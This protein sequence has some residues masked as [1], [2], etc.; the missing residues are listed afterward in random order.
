VLGVT[1]CDVHQRVDPRL[2]VERMDD[3]GIDRG[4]VQDIHLEGEV[5]LPGE[6]GGGAGGGL[7][8]KVG[9]QHPGTLRGEAPCGREPDPGR[10]SDHEDRAVREPRTAGPVLT[11]SVGRR[12]GLHGERIRARSGQRSPGSDQYAFHGSIFLIRCS[13]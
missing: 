5:P 1:A 9:E 10:G 6:L 7:E 8:L 12:R 4:H 2:L 13:S 3:G 11:D